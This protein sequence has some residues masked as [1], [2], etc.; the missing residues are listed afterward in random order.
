MD[1]VRTGPTVARQPVEFDRVAGA[2]FPRVAR[3]DDRPSE[4]ATGTLLRR[5]DLRE[6]MLTSTAYAPP[7]HLSQ[8]AHASAFLL[9]VRRGSFVER[10]GRCTERY[11]GLSC[12]FRPRLDEHANDFESGGAL[13]LAI[14]VSDRWLER[15][16]DAG[17]TGERFGLRSPFVE[18]FADRLET[19]LR[20]PDE[21]SETV[22]EALAT[23]V[24]AFAWRR[25]RRGVHSRKSVWLELA[26]RVIENEFASS[27]SLGRVAAAAHVHPVHL[28]REFRAA[29]GCT[30]GD[31]IRNVR[32][33]FAR[34]RLSTTGDPIAQIAMA[35]GFADQSQLTKSFKRVTGQTPAAYRARK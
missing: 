23:E 26:R 32:V 14:D 13:L 35:A 28:A 25:A 7:R 31:Y 2:P 30:V 9:V 21:L 29:Y 27:L 22:V 19:E 16:H 12:I 3:I 6:S 5:V 24:V 33:S 10:Q 15:L 18:Q 11:D 20:T 4:T 34:R 1:S 8:H 17:F